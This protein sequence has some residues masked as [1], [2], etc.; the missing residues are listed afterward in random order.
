MERTGTTPEPKV[1]KTAGLA[2]KQNR[3]T[4]KG[5]PGQHEG[6]QV[7]LVFRQHPMVM[8]KALIAGMLGMLFGVFPLLFW[9]LSPLAMQIA[10]GAPLAVV[11]YWFRPWVGWYYSVYIVTT[12]RLIEIRQKGFFNRRFTEFGLDKVQN[13]NYRIGGLEAVVL[14]YGD[15]TIQTYVGDLVMPIIHNPV[16]IHQQLVGIIR[17]YNLSSPQAITSTPRSN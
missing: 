9:P 12:E 7:Q 15:I 13:V 11:A 8:R 6:E 3:K 4:A 14:K 17:D 10:L 5:F 16:K 1:Q 2:P